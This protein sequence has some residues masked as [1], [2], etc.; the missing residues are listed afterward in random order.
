MTY[1]TLISTVLLICLSLMLADTWSK[2][3]KSEHKT[4]S[5]IL[6]IATMLYVLFDL[7]WVRFYMAEN[8]KREPLVVMS[9]L[10]YL[11]YITLPYIWFLFAHH[12]ASNIN[13]NKKWMM[14]SS[15]PWFINL[16]LVI[17]T[18]LGTDILWAVGDSENRYV[19]GPLFGVFANLN[20]IYYFIPVI[21]ILILML[22]KP[23]GKSPLL[24][25]TF[26]FSVIPALSVFI[27]TYII[28]VEVVIPFQPSCFFIGVMFAYT[29][30]IT[31]AYKETEEL[32]ARLTERALAA[33]K[34]AELSGSVSAL[35][36]NMP[37]MTFS[38][39]VKTG[40]YL[41]CN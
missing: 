25:R 34:I 9:V 16:G 22:R 4:I 41:A 40:K 19:R 11:I 26:G 18:A 27:H 13:K 23:H 5:V 39:D 1:Y 33:E 28:D 38:K 17:L 37:A 35:L 6:I 29:L 12:F 36:T 14:I 10:F 32:N 20:L 3:A 24:L 7:I 31:T 2:L 15:I 21:E 8:Y 30:L